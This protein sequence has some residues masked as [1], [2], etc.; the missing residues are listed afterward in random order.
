MKQILILCIALGLQIS[1]AQAAD[2][3]GHDVLVGINYFAGWWESLPNKWHGHGWMTNEPDWRLQFPERVPLL[4][5]YNDQATMDREIATAVSHGVDY[6]AI[7]WYFASANNKSVM[8]TPLLNRGLTNFRNSTNAPL[9]KF[10]V[11]YCNHA[12]LSAVTD[13]EWAE[14][15]K[16]WVAAMQHPSYLRVGGRLVFKIH[17]AYQ[18]WMK[19]GKDLG[20]CR[21]RLETLRRAVRAAD[22]GEILIGGG[23]MSGNRVLPDQFVAK[24]FD[25]TATYMSVPAV[26]PRMAEYPYTLL[27]AEARE[28]RAHHAMDPIPWMPYLAAGWNPRPWTHPQAAEHHRTFFTFPTRAEW[29]NELRAVRDDFNRFP[30]LGLPLPNGGR[31]KIFTIYAW[32]E[33]GEGGIM[34]PTQGEGTLKLDCIKAVFD[35][36]RVGK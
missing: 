16:V 6:F 10:M 4:G 11:E 5:C 1:L 8:T 19:N 34:A 3:V 9:M 33:F 23:I 7:L 22:L 18:F 24:L 26:A 14:C 28:A 13:N 20:Q 21:A 25:F 30:T 35:F 2:P 32:N 12:E 36:P 15:V 27:A 17:D 31:Q 29:C